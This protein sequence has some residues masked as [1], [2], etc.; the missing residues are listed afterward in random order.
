MVST[1]SITVLALSSLALAQNAPV[2]TDSPQGVTYV[3]KFVPN[4]KSNISGTVQFEA[5][6]NGSVLVNVDV[7]GLP[8]QGGP[9]PYHIHEKPVPSDGNCTGTLGHLNPFNGTTTSTVAAGKEAGDLAGKHG[10]IT[11]SPF[12]TEFV[13]NYISLN[14]D[15]AAYIGGLS[16]VIHASDNS[17]LT[18]ANIT[19]EDA[20]KSNE[21]E[22]SAVTSANAAGNLVANGFVAGALAGVVA[23]LI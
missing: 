5:A 23:Y 19:K 9:F 17:R 7:Q 11:T 3:A 2:S 1:S 21:T 14:P 6:K 15:N 12:Q 13:D 20:K 16:V 8:S 4:S 10:N 22:T 18:C